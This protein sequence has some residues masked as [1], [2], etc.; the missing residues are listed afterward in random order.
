[1]TT[2][3]IIAQALIGGLLY[4]GISLILEKSLSAQAM[5]TKGAEALIFTLVYGIGLWAYHKFVKK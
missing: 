2:Q 1:M 4:F 5:Q 3:R